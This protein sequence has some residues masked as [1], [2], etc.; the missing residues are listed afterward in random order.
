[1]RFVRTP[2]T[3]SERKRLLS[4]LSMPPEH[5][6]P[7]LLG[8]LLVRKTGGRVIVARIVET[9]AYLGQ[10]DPAAHAFK[11]RT[12]RT[13]PLWGPP[14]TWYV[15]FIYGMHHCLNITVE[16][17]GR[18]G[19]VLIRA[20][21]IFKES[22]DRGRGPGRLTRALKVNRTLSGIRAFDRDCGLW[23]R[24]GRAPE[25]VSVSPRIGIRHATEKA[26]RFFEAGSRSVSS[27]RPPQALEARGCV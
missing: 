23:L 16:P 21:E 11:G 15:Y 17:E 7:A 5:A 27:P 12:P 8:A 2:A 18:P 19:C 20:A 1:M 26:L 6:A 13:D 10:N 14:G 25:N 22:P 3:R 4:T 24:E 9:E